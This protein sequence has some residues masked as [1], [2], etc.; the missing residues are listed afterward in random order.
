MIKLSPP[1]RK[2]TEEDA[3]VL[4]QLVNAAGE[5]LAE[6]IW[7]KIARS[8]PGPDKPDPWEIGIKR[9]A[10]MALKGKVIVLEAEGEPAAGLTG[11]A[12][13]QVPEPIP[14]NMP[15][16][17]IPLQEL[18]NTAP[19]TWYINV[20]AALPRHRSKGYGSKL[21]KLSEDIARNDNL[22]GLSLIVADNNFRARNLYER[23]GFIE[24]SRKPVIRENWATE[25]QEWVLLTKIFSTN[26]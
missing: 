23:S 4:A 10:K 25:A 22:S 8:F 2:A 6:Y 26:D 19:N 21:L 11:Y 16:M 12:I 24:E 17:F 15:E 5:G 20:L 3:D 9:Q 14:A 7:I 18:E 1:F 13:P